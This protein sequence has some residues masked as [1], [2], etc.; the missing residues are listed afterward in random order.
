MPKREKEKGKHSLVVM[1]EKQRVK[2]SRA[3]SRSCKSM[4]SFTQ[5][6]LLRTREIVHEA[7]P[8]FLDDAWLPPF[9]ILAT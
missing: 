9:P 7:T 6:S 1:E 5:I 8:Q 4:K 3:K 2:S